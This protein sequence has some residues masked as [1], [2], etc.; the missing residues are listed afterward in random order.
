LAEAVKWY[1]KAA[2]KGIDEAQY[3]LGVAYARGIGVAQNTPEALKWFR[4]A[5]AQDY[6]PAKTQI[7]KLESKSK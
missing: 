2:E 7:R 4:R 6:G 1:H 5:A 3:D